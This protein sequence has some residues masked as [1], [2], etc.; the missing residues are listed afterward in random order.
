[1]RARR[2]TLTYPP[3]PGVDPSVSRSC[4]PDTFKR[5][6]ITFQA[7]LI[8][9]IKERILGP[10]TRVLGTVEGRGDAS[11]L[12]HKGGF[13]PRPA[14]LSQ[15][16]G[17]TFSMPTTVVTVRGLRRVAITT[18]HAN[19]VQYAVKNVTNTP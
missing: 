8:I 5:K 1:M 19:G 9:I 15:L 6:C 18:R 7:A 17:V 2:P 10:L 14:A 16:Q 13:S 4:H 11:T 3:Y 12:L